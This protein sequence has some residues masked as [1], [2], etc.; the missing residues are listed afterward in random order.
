MA[1]ERNK[2]FLLEIFLN[3]F[4]QIEYTVGKQDRYIILNV[5]NL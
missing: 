1:C 2:D 3:K 5:S 4:K